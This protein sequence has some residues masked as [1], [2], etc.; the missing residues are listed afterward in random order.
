MTGSSRP[1]EEGDEAIGYGC[2]RAAGELAELALEIGPDKLGEKKH[3]QPT[4]RA[5]L[6]ERL[7][8][9]VSPCEMKLPLPGWKPQPGAID[10]VVSDERRELPCYL[11]EL[12]W[13]ADVWTLGWS[14]WDIY[15]MVA[16]SQLA[17]VEAC[18]VVAGAPV[19]FWSRRDHCAP[20]F[21]TA[22]WDSFDLFHRFREDWQELLRGGPA[23]PTHVP[24]VIETRLVADIPLAVGTK[25][26]RLRAISARAGRLEFDGDWPA[27]MVYQAG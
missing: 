15:K 21:A 13:C 2:R 1:P 22:A 26:W 19:G 5:A 4:F 14:L 10:I 24:T 6:A 25:D 17:G 18:Y 16:A 27:G 9:R 12:K 11:A 23:R 3:L 7:G 20:L 8:D